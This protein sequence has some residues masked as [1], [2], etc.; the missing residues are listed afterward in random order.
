MTQFLS[1]DNPGTCHTC[2]K[3]A[4]GILAANG[5]I[6]CFPCYRLARAKDKLAAHRLATATTCKPCRIFDCKGY[7]W[8]Q[9]THDFEADIHRLERPEQY[10]HNDKIPF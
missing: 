3:V 6:V 9:T 8:V 10:K 5:M 2:S 7:W 4:T 1:F